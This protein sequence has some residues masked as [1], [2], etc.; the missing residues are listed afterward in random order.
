MAPAV[1]ALPVP[2]GERLDLLRPAG[3]ALAGDGPALLPLPGRRPAPVAQLA[4]ALQRG[5]RWPTARTTRRPDR[6]RRR[7]LRLHRR[8]RR[9]PCSPASALRASAAADPAPRSAAATG[10]LAAGAARPPHRRVA[11]AAALRWPR[12]ARRRPGHR[13]AVHRRPVRRARWPRCRDRSAVRVAG[14]RP[15]CTASWPIRRPTAALPPSTPC[16]SA[17]PR[18]PPTCS[19]T[20]RQAGITVVTSYGMSETCGGCVYDGRPLDGVTVDP[21]RPTGRPDQPAGPVVARGLPGRP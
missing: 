17:G 12:D 4:A 20:P 11:G 10:R 16:W 21:D 9:A 7:D 8:A 2:T 6:V 1:R 5:A 3:R 14:A 18:P 19:T 13:P 15:S